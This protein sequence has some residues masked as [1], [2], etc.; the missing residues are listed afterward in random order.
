[1]N[2]R[3]VRILSDFSNMCGD[4]GRAMRNCN[5]LKKYVKTMIKR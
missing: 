4:E 1:M 3:V 2:L 5:I